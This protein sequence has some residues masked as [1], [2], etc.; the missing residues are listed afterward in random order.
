MKGK[1][2][3]I[4]LTAVILMSASA[5]AKQQQDTINYIGERPTTGPFFAEDE[6]PLIEINYH[7]GDK[8]ASQLDEV[9]PLGSP[10]TVTVF[11]LR[12]STLK[13]DFAQIATEQVASRLA[14]K[15]YAIVADNSRFSMKAAS[16]GVEPP[17]KCVLAGSYTVGPE[18]IYMTAAISTIDDGEILGSWDWTVPLNGQ[19][20]SLLPNAE[21]IDITPMVNTSGPL[22]NQDKDMN[23]FQPSYSQQPD[24]IL[25]GF[26]QNILN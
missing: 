23:S 25:P 18:L 19:T 2:F 14:Q 12:G 20:K 13:T 9:L 24:R 16:E 8:I 5:C 11:R 3:I 22:S 21:D 7:A 4:V 26:E 17:E 10:I 15:G 6:T 1:K